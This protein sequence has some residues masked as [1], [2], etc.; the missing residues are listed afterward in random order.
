[1]KGRQIGSEGYAGPKQ[2]DKDVELSR[3]RY[4]KWM[5]LTKPY[6]GREG[7][8]PD[9]EFLL[10]QLPLDGGSVLDCGCTR[11][12]HLQHEKCQTKKITQCGSP[13]QDGSLCARPLGHSS[14]CRSQSMLER[15]RRDRRERTKRERRQ[16]ERARG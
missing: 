5:E 2:T 7:D 4:E 3:R 8:S 16:R 6:Q 1:M 10:S 13:R 9:F 15:Q 12:E 14:S 11:F